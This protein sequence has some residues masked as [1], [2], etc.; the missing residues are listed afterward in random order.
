MIYSKINN[1]VRIAQDVTG[2]HATIVTTPYLSLIA[3]SQQ[4][5]KAALDEELYEKRTLDKTRCVRKTIYTHTKEMIPLVH[6]A[7][8]SA[9]E[10]A[11]RRYMES[12]DV[13]FAEYEDISGE[14]LGLP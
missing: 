13:S 7:T 4:F 14:I 12:P 8:T 6:A 5:E 3:R 1:P 2:L 10:K 11:S 9:V